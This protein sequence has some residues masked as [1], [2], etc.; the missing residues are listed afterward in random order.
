MLVGSP[1]PEAVAKALLSD[2][3]FGPYIEASTTG[4]AN[5]AGAIA[6]ISASGD[7]GNSEIAKTSG[8]SSAGREAKAAPALYPSLSGQD[9]SI[10]EAI[11]PASKEEKK[12]PSPAHP[13]LSITAPPAAQAASLKQDSEPPPVYIT[14]PSQEGTKFPA[15]FP[16]PSGGSTAASKDKKTEGESSSEDHSSSDDDDDDF[17]SS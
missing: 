11:S 8:D 17:S 1:E 2:P 12:S 6:G 3:K 15:L 4:V 9:G 16:G 7:T 14:Q 13:A 5:L 10:P